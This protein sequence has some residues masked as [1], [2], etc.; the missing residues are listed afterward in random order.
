MWW[1]KFVVIYESSRGFFKLPQKRYLL[2]SIAIALTIKPLVL[3]WVLSTIASLSI[4]QPTLQA[5]AGLGYIE[6]FSLGLEYSWKSKHSVS[7]HYGSNVFINSDQFSTVF[8]K[9]NRTVN[10]LTFQKNRPGIGLK[11]GS[12]IFTD[13]FYRWKVSSAVPFI[14]LR[15]TF[16]RKLEAGIETGIALSRIESVTRINYGEIGKYKRYLP[17][18]NFTLHYTL[19]K[20]RH[21]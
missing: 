5:Q 8:I 12:S 2:P 10:G 18:L 20:K 13:D 7:L 6:H 4:A 11:L 15:H 3:L 21:E 19:L 14:S 16:N 17:E 1:Y 9:Y